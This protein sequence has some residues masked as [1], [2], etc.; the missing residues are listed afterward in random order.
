MHKHLTGMC[1]GCRR[2][3][4]LL[5]EPSTIC[6]PLVAA[7]YSGVRRTFLTDL[8]TCLYCWPE[9]DHRDLTVAKPKSPIFTVKLSSW[10]NI[11]L[12]FRSLKG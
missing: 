8:L 10:R 4:L 5:L 7:K 2:S 12:D 1:K 6:C 3:F 11:L 9:P